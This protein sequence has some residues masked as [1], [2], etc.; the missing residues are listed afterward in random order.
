[1]TIAIALFH[2]AT[3]RRLLGAVLVAQWLLISTA[4]AEPVDWSSTFGR[5]PL[6]FERIDDARFMAR[7]DGYLVAVDGPKGAIALEHDLVKF[8]FVG[9]HTGEVRP[10]ASLSGTVNHV[11]GSSPSGWR[12][13]IPTFERVTYSG[14]YPGVDLIYYGNQRN[15]EFDLVLHE[16][17]DPRDI[18]LRVA[19]G[20]NIRIDE[21]GNLAIGDLQLKAPRISQDGRPVAGRYFILQD[22]SVGFEI[23]TYDP[24]RPLVIDPTLVYATRVGGGRGGNQAN[25]IAVDGSGST[26][27]AGHTASADFPVAAAA[28][29]GY[30]SNTDAFV[31]KLAPDGTSLVFSTYLGGSGVDVIQS[32]AVDPA[33][34]VWVSG[35]T[36]SNNFPLVSPLQPQL[37]GALDAVVVKLGPTGNVVYSTL[38]GARASDIAYAIA[39]DPRGNA[40][41]AGET[42]EDFPTTDGVYRRSAQSLDGFVTKLS[43]AGR[44]LWSTLV[45]GPSADGIRGIAVDQFGSAYVTGWTVSPS[46]PGAP[47]GGV[48]PANQGGGDAFVAKLNFDASGLLYFT[49][50]GGSGADLASAIAVQGPSREAVI[51]GDTTSTDLA[52][53]VGAAQS[54]MSGAR[55]GFIARIDSSGSRMAYLTYLGGSRMDVLTAIS[56]DAAGNAYVGG[57]SQSTGF[58]TVSALQA[59]IQ[60][61]GTGLFRTQN[62]GATWTPFDANLLGAAVDASPDPLASSTIVVSTESGIFR[63]TNGGSS[64]TQQSNVGGLRLARSAA[65]GNVIY[66]TTGSAVY[67]SMDGGATWAFRGSIQCCAGDIVADATNA[68]T[69]YAFNQYLPGAPGIQR[70][71]DGGATWS[72]AVSGLPDNAAVTAVVSGSDGSLYAGL[73][74]GSYPSGLY[75]SVNRGATWVLLS[76]GLPSTLGVPPGGLAIASSAP[77]VVYVTDYFNLYRSATSGTSWEFVS[78]LPGGTTALAVSRS[79]SATLFYSAY[80]SASPMWVSRDSGATWTPATG[81]GLASLSPVEV[82]PTSVASAYAVAAVNVVPVVAKLTASGA[83]AYSTYLGDYGAVYG[84]ASSSGQAYVA[85]STWDIPT[86]PG[87]V[88]AHRDPYFNNLDGFVAKIADLTAPCSFSVS[89]S[90][91]LEIWF[92]H[93]VR[94]FVTAPSG[95]AWTASSDQ[96]WAQIVGNASG[97]GSGIV[98]VLANNPYNSTN[99]SATLTIAGQVVRLRQPTGTCGYSSIDPGTTVIPGVGGRVSFNVTANPGCDW[100]LINNHM[101]AVT[102]TSADRGTGSASVA[103]TVA[104]NLGPNTRTFELVSAQGGRITISQ[105]GTTAPTVTSTISSVPPGATVTVSGAGCIP[106]TY[107]TPANLT[108]N[109]NT[110]CS[111]GFSSP[112]MIGGTQHVFVSAAANGGSSSSSNPL[113]VN[114]GSAAVT[115]GAIFMAP[116]TYALSPANR[117][118][119][120]A[121]GPSSF[122]VLTG[123]TCRYTAIAS[124][125]WI[126]VLP[127]A[128]VGTGT[129]NF[130]VRANSGST[131]RS[132]SINVGDQTYTINQSGYSCTYSLSPVDASVGRTGGTTRAFVSAPSQCSWSTTSNASWLSVTP[133]SGSGSRDVQITVRTNS[134]AERSGTVRIAGQTFSVTQNAATGGPGACGATDATSQVSI[135]YGGFGPPSVSGIFLQRV[136][137]RNTSSTFIPP[138]IN[139]VLVG[140]PSPGVRLARGFPLT[141]CFTSDGDSMFGP[142]ISD[143]IPPGGSVTLEFDFL[144]DFPAR[145]RYS[146]KVLSGTPSR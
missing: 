72:V 142:L 115:I 75:K 123:P 5:V 86:T 36:N 40:F 61:N 31:S 136:Q 42:A 71:T 144:A 53:T 62:A 89:P 67:R 51:A 119:P 15:L 102:F 33:G 49:F 22:Q 6:Y 112:Q 65:G 96:A 141:R 110:N 92:T 118:F 24:G 21:D 8:E 138:P 106:G 91:A 44:L 37:S 121:G 68:D 127:S 137:I 125:T 10:G 69:V 7:G 94:F 111:V 11:T 85:G 46:F 13:G 113:T 30:Q 129:V 32:I 84:I 18:R 97:V 54:T 70:T 4:F 52:V 25:A 124:A 29:A 104:P 133:G 122:R 76:A 3:S 105:P 126:D 116:C 1:M 107:T 93:V 2:A 132:G 130:V 143:G 20:R 50:L 90:D 23:G 145:P 77:G 12:Q 79:D 98:Y 95:C 34:A 83:L 131:G 135:G 58:P 35:Y 43:P 9:A 19:E 41:V 81:L 146:L 60:G 82:D 87:A 103:L 120:S 88:Q 64:W 134:G 48:Q 139:L 78:S 114:S 38:L 26:Y 109:G 28:Y 27:I 73:A 74:G 14:I 17:A 108:W 59:G 128:S 101:S 45:G 47:T 39:V 16:R 140:V 57:Y 100:R 56:T 55:D 80:Y 117:S 66:G 63:T 99:Q